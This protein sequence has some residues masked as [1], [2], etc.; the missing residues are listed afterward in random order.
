ML[1]PALTPTRCFR[2]PHHRRVSS[3]KLK[4]VL[5]KGTFFETDDG[6]GK[7][8]VEIADALMIR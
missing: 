6:K 2:L 7:N 5:R 3:C 1:L 4:E 8:E